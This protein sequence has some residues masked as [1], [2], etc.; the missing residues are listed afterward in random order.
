M[1]RGGGCSLIPF[2]FGFVMGLIFFVAAMA[3]T[4]YFA[5]NV[6][7][8]KQIENM[9][10]ADIPLT[11]QIKIDNT[12]LSYIMKLE[13]YINDPGSLTLKDLNEK[14]GVKVSKKADWLF[15]VSLDPI[16]D[17]PMKD[18]GEYTDVILN[19]ILLRDAKN[20]F[21]FALPNVPAYT[22]TK[23]DK[24]YDDLKA[25]DDLTDL[26]ILIDCE[27]VKVTNAGKFIDD[28]V[29]GNPP[30]GIEAALKVPPDDLY[31]LLDDMGTIDA[32][33]I[34]GNVNLQNCYIY[35]IVDVGNEAP[36]S[37]MAKL[38]TKT[39]P[40]GDPE[41]G[42]PFK[43]SEIKGAMKELT[44]YDVFPTECVTPGNIFSLLC[45][46]DPANNPADAPKLGKLDDAFKD[47][48]EHK[49]LG[50]FA[51]AGIITAPFPNTRL[52]NQNPKDFI[53]TVFNLETLSLK[54][55]Y[56]IGLIENPPLP[57]YEDNLIGTI[58]APFLQ[59]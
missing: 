34:I 28:Y 16:W 46:A 55:L 20:A 21:G 59:P 54:K 1:R 10:G 26:F 50:D 18:Y 22:Y 29:D 17:K 27:Y 7:T 14:L 2:I 5:L 38:A 53:E 57:A 47:A 58:I 11:E 19:Q 49:T 33:D 31:M 9:T 13:P 36:G 25:K 24:V 52:E 39:K 48:F 32:F 43:L 8:L 6:L 12:T 4:L 51:A 3:G 40:V 30:F 44:L 45:G 37:L 35:E 56:A 15:N 41:E 42:Q 23:I